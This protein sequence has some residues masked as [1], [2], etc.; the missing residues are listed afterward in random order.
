M[1]DRDGSG[2]IDSKELVVVISHLSQGAQPSKD[3]LDT[4]MKKMDE[5]GDGVIQW[6]EFLTA[7]SSWI[8]EE[9]ETKDA[10]G[11]ASRKRK[12]APTSAQQAR[13][14]I[15]R[16]ISGFFNHV[17]KTPNHDRLRE[18]YQEAQSREAHREEG[19]SFQE[20][21]AQD[22]VNCIEET[23]RSLP[24]L[25]QIVMLINRVDSEPAAI[26]GTKQLAD[27]LSVCETLRV[28]EERY[29]AA[30][31]LLQVFNNVQEAGVITR[32]CSFLR[33]EKTSAE[34]HFHALRVITYY[35]PGPRIPHT[36]KESLHHPSKM[37]HKGDML[38]S[39]AFHSLGAFL[40]H[41]DQRL[42]EQ[43]ILAVGRLASHDPDARNACLDL[44]H[45]KIMNNT[46]N[47]ATPPALAEKLTWAMSVM[48]GHTHPRS[49]APRYDQVSLVLPT[50]RYFLLHPSDIVKNNALVALSHLLPGH[51]FDP[52]LASRFI[53]LL[54]KS[55]SRIQSLVLSI[56]DE[57][58]FID[59]QAKS[60]NPVA[61]H[62]MEAGLLAAVHKVLSEST[63]HN[64]RREALELLCLLADSYTNP[65]TYSIVPAMLDSKLVPDLVHFLVNDDTL[66]VKVVKVFRSLACAG[67][68]VTTRLVEKEELI[69]I[70]VTSMSFF[71]NYDKVLRDV[72]QFFG[73]SYNFEYLLDIVTTL[74]TI[75]ATG[76]VVPNPAENPFIK[77]FDMDVIDKIRQFFVNFSEEL[78]VALPSW[79]TPL[80]AAD[81]SRVPLE[82]RLLGL[83]E[84]IHTMHQQ[85]RLPG[86]EVLCST[87]QTIAIRYQE[88]LKKGAEKLLTMRASGQLGDGKTEGM[89]DAAA[90]PTG[91]MVS[92]TCLFDGDN[93]LID[94][95]SNI[96]YSDLLARV[97]IRYDRAVIVGYTTADGT[98]ITIDSPEVLQRAMAHFAAIGSYKLM[99]RPSGGYAGSATGA[100]G[101]GALGDTTGTSVITDRNKT[102]VLSELQRRLQVEPK[103]LR[104]MMESYQKRTGGQGPLTRG[105]VEGFLREDCKIYD[106]AKVTALVDAFDR[107]KDGTIDF[108]EFATTLCIMSKGSYDERIRLVFDTYDRD[109][110]GRVDRGELAE[111]FRASARLAGFPL[112]E[113]HVN[114]MVQEAF[115]KFDA[116]GDGGLDFYEFRAA[117]S[118]NQVAIA[119][120]WTNNL[121]E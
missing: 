4:L 15:H 69:K 13:L 60:A 32:V 81:P 5:N 56:I 65:A 108:A 58:I 35:G 94:V 44:E 26:Q 121:F 47:A 61:K 55:S 6:S 40:T 37:K 76:R 100:T 33:D 88:D 105:Q 95:P 18:L 24:Q 48:C 25:L 80:A 7:I 12:E 70:L 63:E 101:S 82:R 51:E 91:P 117:V 85:A 83:L 74:E 78:T 41:P 92:M 3:E 97:A 93:R 72:Y 23:K 102:A 27:M 109:K 14:K 16:Q 30:N 1:V 98:V 120:F 9:E 112:S 28:P 119:A 115:A 62:L 8:V 19:G 29:E 116:N 66:R 89:S 59:V 96:S 54:V 113:A 111:I 87:L 50:L 104:Q 11:S 99:V 31:L 103:L 34:L 42:R 10:S 90:G 57:L 110:S 118:Q 64:V 36:P 39:G 38:R 43:A 45:L 71:K 20:Y 86:S 21:S 68:Y 84:N 77:Y 107:N 79:G 2:S 46:L 52:S 75:I 114:M 17:R 53:E 106:A 73:A 22:K 67:T 49:K